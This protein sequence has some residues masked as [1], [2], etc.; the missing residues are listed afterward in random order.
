M[1]KLK[2]LRIQKKLTQKQVADKLCVSESTVCLYE[3]G[4]RT[5]NIDMLLKYASIYNC[6]LDELVV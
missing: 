4:Q 1:L 5:P 3:K 2:E 6:T